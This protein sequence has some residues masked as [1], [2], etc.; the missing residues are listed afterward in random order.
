RLIAGVAVAVKVSFDWKAKGR[1]D[2]KHISIADP[3]GRTSAYTNNRPRSSAMDL[4]IVNY[5]LRHYL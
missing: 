1:S 2:H 5:R 4:A 3:F